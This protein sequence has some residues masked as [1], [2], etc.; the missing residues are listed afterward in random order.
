MAFRELIGNAVG[1][2]T[3]YGYEKYLGLP[4]V[5]GRAKK[6]AFADIVGRVQARLEGWKERMFSQAGREILIKVVI[7]RSQRI[8]CPSF[9]SLKLYAK[10]LIF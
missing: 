2:T 8:T 9:Y 3:T 10:S 5:I 6:A 7:R 4:A 1:H